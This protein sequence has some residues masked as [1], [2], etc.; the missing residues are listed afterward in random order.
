M[1]HRSKRFHGNTGGGTVKPYKDL[2][3][4]PEYRML[5]LK[6]LAFFP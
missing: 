6:N 2:N 3:Q 1:E 4:E 5:S